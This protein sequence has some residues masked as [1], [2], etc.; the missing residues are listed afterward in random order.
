MFSEVHFVLGFSTQQV[1]RGLDI[2]PGLRNERHV[3]LYISNWM[4]PEPAVHII[5]CKNDNPVL[6]EMHFVPGEFPPSRLL[7]ANSFEMSA[8]ESQSL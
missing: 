1:Q 2:R 6:S 8:R 4:F 5:A 7:T 3:L